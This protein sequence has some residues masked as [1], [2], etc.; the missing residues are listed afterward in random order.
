MEYLFDCGSLCR[1][2]ATDYIHSLKKGIFQS[3]LYSQPF[4]LARFR[5]IKLDSH[6][7]SLAW[8]G[9]P[10]SA[11]DSGFEFPIGLSFGAGTD[12]QANWFH[13]S[14]CAYK[15]LIR[16][17]FFVSRICT[18]RTLLS[19]HKS[20][21]QYTDVWRYELDEMIALSLIA[22][23]D[24]R[25][26]MSNR[27][28]KLGLRLNQSH[29]SERSQRM[30]LWLS[31]LKQLSHEHADCSLVYGCLRRYVYRL[32]NL[33]FRTGTFTNWS[34]EKLLEYAMA[35]VNERTSFEVIDKC[36]I[37]FRSH[38]MLEESLFECMCNSDH[39]SRVVDSLVPIER[40][41]YAPNIINELY[42][43]LGK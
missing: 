33:H 18:Y 42:A 24:F 11:D 43:T 4:K 38:V 34:L 8:F 35:H 12:S 13:W 22:R 21:E 19:V 20:S 27:R 36:S 5:W 16:Y 3:W 6:M 14:D 28:Q 25:L 1:G 41:E 17:L 10:D 39:P 32:L 29:L 37:H 23:N 26:A 9:I 2:T 30:L 7:Y 31:R 40:S 15:S